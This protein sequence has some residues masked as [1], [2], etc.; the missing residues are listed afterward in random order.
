MSACTGPGTGIDGCGRTSYV[1]TASTALDGGG[2]CLPDCRYYSDGGF[3]VNS[4]NAAT[5]YCQ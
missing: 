3:C 1:C 5:G 4:C 2:Y